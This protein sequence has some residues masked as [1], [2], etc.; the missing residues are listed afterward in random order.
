MVEFRVSGEFRV[1][2]PNAPFRL[3]MKAPG[4]KYLN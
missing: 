1:E 4:S 3:R 2:G